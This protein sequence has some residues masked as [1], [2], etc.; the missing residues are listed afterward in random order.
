MAGPVTSLGRQPTTPSPAVQKA[1]QRY[2]NKAS[3]KME[4]AQQIH[5]YRAPAPASPP[6]HNVSN[7]TH[8]V[9]RTTQAT[10]QPAV[11]FINKSPAE[12]E[13]LARQLTAAEISGVR[14]AYAPQNTLLE[15]ER[16]PALASHATA[17]GQ[18]GATLGGLQTQQAA[19]AKT[20]ENYSADALSKAA[21]AAPGAEQT[22]ATLGLKPGEAL[23]QGLQQQ[24]ENARTLLSG[25]AQGQAARANESSQNEANFLTNAQSTAAIRNA[26]GVRNIEGAFAR[27]KQEVAGK[28]GAAIAKAQG[29]QASL[30]QKLFGEQEKLRSTKEAI[31]GKKFEAETKAATAASKIHTEAAKLG[32]EGKKIAQTGQKQAADEAYKKAGLEQK[33]RVDESTIKKNEAYIKK[34]LNETRPGGGKPLTTAQKNTLTGEAA[35]IFNAMHRGIQEG[36][37]PAT[38]KQELEQGSARRKSFKFNSKG[39]ETP[40]VVTIHF[41]AVKNP[42]LASV[43]EQSIN[44]GYVDAP[45]K[46][47]LREAG[48][49]DSGWS[50]GLFAQAGAKRNATTGVTG[51]VNAEKKKK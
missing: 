25:I 9:T 21:T 4:T 50:S 51:G 41:K 47:Q 7:T 40:T 16:G 12:V 46:Q 19:S 31:T 8:T 2:L 32:N 11:S 14:G 27:Q 24:Q 17:Y 36:I 42:L 48:L 37:A 13:S 22:R 6:G 5:N 23:P 30:A 20:F 10:P 33:S 18:L 26:E 45:T 1:A 29:N 43:A 44:N 49:P 28:E 39:E 3:G 35:V 38:V 15:Q 34:L